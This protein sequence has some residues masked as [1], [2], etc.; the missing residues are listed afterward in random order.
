MCEDYFLI[1]GVLFKTKYDQDRTAVLC[2]PE[3][4]VP[5]ILYQYHDEILAGHPGVHK[6]IATISKKYYFPGMHTIIREY[7]IIV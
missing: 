4:Y 1:E 2:I 3:K 5:V 7:V 6:L